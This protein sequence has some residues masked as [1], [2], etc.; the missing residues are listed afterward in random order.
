MKKNIYSAVVGF[1]VSALGIQTLP[2]D[3]AG[4]LAFSPEQDEKIKESFGEKYEAALK[5]AQEV[6]DEE[7]GLDAQ[8]QAALE[9]LATAAGTD[10]VEKPTIE[11]PAP[12]INAAT[13]KIEEQQK[14]IE[15]MANQPEPDEVV[16][17]L[18]AGAKA[19]GIAAMIALTSPTALFG[20]EQNKEF[21][22][23]APWN[24]RCALELDNKSAAV[25]DFTDSSTI[26]RLNDD[27]KEYYVRNP[28]VLKEL[29]KDRFGLPSFWPKEFNVVDQISDAVIDVANVTQGRK[30]E[31]SPNPD[32]FIAAE[33][34]KNYPVQIDIQF[35]GY[36]LQKLETSWINTLFDMDGSSP[37]KLSFVAFLVQKIDT[38]ARLEDRISSIN[39]VYV[40]KPAGIKAKGHFLNRQNGLK[41]Q[42]YKFRDL[43]K[44]ILAFRSTLGSISTANA[45]DYFK[46]F[47]MWLPN[48]VRMALGMKIYLSQNL[49]NA[50]REGYKI[51]NQLANNYTGDDLK[52]IDGYSNLEFVVLG[53]LE[54]TNVFFMTDNE[55]IQILE[56]VPNEKSIYRFEYLKRDTFIHAD[57]KQA[58]A[59]VHAGYKLPANSEFLGLAQMIWI[60]DAPLFSENFYV[61]MY[62]DAITG[63]VE[64]NFNRIETHKDLLT[65]VHT[66]NS[67]MPVGHLI[68]IKGNTKQTTTAVIKDKVGEVGNID[69]TADFNPKL[70]GTLTLIKTAT[71]FKEVSR[72]AAPTG[73]G[74]S[75][76]AFTS[77]SID[78]KS[79]S[80]FA[81]TGTSAVEL[82]TILNGVEGAEIKIYGQATNTLTVDT[83]A[84]KI[85]VTGVEAVLDGPAKFITLKKFDGIWVEISRG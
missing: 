20:M 34:R 22:R 27:L 45:Y 7:N 70:G 38:Q 72:A 73:A 33:K 64:V 16:R 19:F 15:K 46:E 14:Q 55:N 24:K 84:G 68:K 26:A 18:Q 77:T 83:V 60:N 8:K 66:F 71:G 76:V 79:G 36:Q 32:F 41:Y 3:D 50:Y 40:F 10:P 47:V 11:N 1:L 21:S 67:E 4:K 44:K 75:A 23:D 9:A 59:F 81:Y 54:G 69:L 61:P 37:Y 35:S 53:D 63:T 85:Q 80:E 25:T 49:L 42:L 2:K 31:W 13:Q 39:G 58:C 52:A 56:D 17:K 5:A 12:V 30:P 28:Q 62:G 74:S 65:D 51:A 43:E 78:A 6:L 57:Y 48:D 29:K 82:A